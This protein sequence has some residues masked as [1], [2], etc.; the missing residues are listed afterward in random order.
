MLDSNDL[1]KVRDLIREEVNTA[2]SPLKKDIKSL[3]KS[4]SKIIKTLD[5]A[6][7]FFDEDHVKLVR[8]VDRIENHLK[9]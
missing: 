2:T 3:K 7:K 1:V 6:I 8:R 4:V 9:L 5:V